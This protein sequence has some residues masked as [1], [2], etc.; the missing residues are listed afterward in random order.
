MVHIGVVADTHV[1]ESL[2][3]LP[4]AVME[5]LA[6]VDLVLHAGDVVEPAALAVLS[7]LAPVVAVQGDHDRMAGVELPPARVVRVGDVRIGLVHG[8][9][10]RAVELAMVLATLALGRWCPL[11]FHRA[12]RRRFRR[13]D[14]VVHGHLHLPT[15]RRVRGAL[16]FS[17]GAVYVPEA[18]PGYDR[19]RLRHR[20]YLAFRRRLPPAARVPAVGLIELGPEG[21]RVSVLPLDVPAGQPPADPRDRHGQQQ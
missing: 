4:A 18:D 13:V 1:G 19:D 14:L 17:P 9:R 16:V 10:P 5:R 21:P 7:R 12:V 15:R 20:L 2:P 8:T 11:G 6:G 3:E